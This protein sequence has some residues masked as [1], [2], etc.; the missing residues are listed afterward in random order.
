MTLSIRY[1]LSHYYS[2]F[3]YLPTIHLIHKHEILMDVLITLELYV[4]QYSNYTSSF[5]SIQIRL[6][7]IFT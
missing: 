5:N 4:H 1:Y 3:H 2:T 6:F 7:N